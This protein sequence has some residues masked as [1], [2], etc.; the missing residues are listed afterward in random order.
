MRILK[1]NLGDKYGIIEL[2]K[3]SNFFNI[4]TGNI[5]FANGY[6]L[7]INT[8][9]RFTDSFEIDNSYYFDI[10]LIDEDNKKIC[11]DINHF[12]YNYFEEHDPDSF[13]YLSNDFTWVDMNLNSVIEKCKFI[14]LLPII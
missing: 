7:C 8:V 3:H 1:L 14:E 5:C 13:T 12:L 4:V 10:N 2:T 9:D 11:I 6:G